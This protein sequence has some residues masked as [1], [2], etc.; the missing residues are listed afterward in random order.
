MRAVHV[1]ER[2]RRRCALEFVV[3]AMGRI[4]EAT[5]IS[6]G[7][8]AF[9]GR[10]RL[11]GLAAGGRQPEL[12]RDFEALRDS[13]K[14]TMHISTLRRRAQLPCS[15]CLLHAIRTSQLCR[16]CFAPWLG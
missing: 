16:Y 14:R 9:T 4:G 12:E 5:T 7:R 10:S 6:L 13:Q 3:A 2:E 11:A 1:P 15:K 8:A